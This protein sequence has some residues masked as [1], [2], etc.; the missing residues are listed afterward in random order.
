[1]GVLDEKL[2]NYIATLLY[3][4]PMPSPKRYILNFL[5]FLALLFVFVF[6]G[7]GQVANDTSGPIF[8]DPSEKI[9]LLSNEAF[10]ATLFYEAIN[11]E[12]LL[13]QVNTQVNLG[14]WSLYPNRAYL[15]VLLDD[16]NNYVSTLEAIHRAIW[17]EGTTTSS[18]KQYPSYITMNREYWYE[19]AAGS[20]GIVTIEGKTYT[21]PYPVTYAQADLIWGLYSQRYTEMASLFSQ[22]T[23]R[24]V[25]AWCFVQGARAVRI[26]YSYEFPK[27][28]TL[29]ALGDV[30]VN[31]AL[32]TEA[33]WQN[34]AQW[35][36]GTSNA[37]T[38]EP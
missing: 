37:P 14:F 13:N 35:V 10:T 6:S 4:L 27:L 29:E 34:P 23:G 17:D 36:I 20:G 5:V 16:I 22:A 2:H 7:C 24:T 8:T 26:F 9:A 19:R 28:A 21:D 25:E 11:L 15:I 18:S 32:T 1:L 12:P 33:D 31:F 30:I 3:N 38:P